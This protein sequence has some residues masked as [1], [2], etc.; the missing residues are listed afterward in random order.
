MGKGED[1]KIV[2][3]IQGGRMFSLSM[4]EVRFDDFSWDYYNPL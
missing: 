2:L 1:V 3:M 4:E